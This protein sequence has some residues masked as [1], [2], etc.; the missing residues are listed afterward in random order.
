MQRHIFVKVDVPVR[1]LQ[2]PAP[3]PKGKRN[4]S[5]RTPQ[6]AAVENAAIAANSSLKV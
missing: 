4:N 5:T 3:F 2:S 1:G 6:A